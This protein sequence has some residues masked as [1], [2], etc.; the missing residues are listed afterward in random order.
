MK[1]KMSVNKI[2]KNKNTTATTYL[3]DLEARRKM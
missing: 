2:K 1:N 3:P